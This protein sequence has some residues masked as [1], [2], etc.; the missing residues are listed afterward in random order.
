MVSPDFKVLALSVSELTIMYI[1]QNF[2]NKNSFWIFI[3]IMILLS[4]VV[5]FLVL[6]AVCRENKEK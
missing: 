3:G 1:I 6:C 4:S 5:C 2:F